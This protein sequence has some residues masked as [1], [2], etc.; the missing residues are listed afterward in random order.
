MNPNIID[1]NHLFKRLHSNKRKKWTIWLHFI[2][3][4]DSCKIIVAFDILVYFM[5]EMGGGGIIHNNLISRK[6][7][8]TP[9]KKCL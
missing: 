7:C 8:K 5:R 1:M 9:Q 3:L 4:F 2:I 6:N